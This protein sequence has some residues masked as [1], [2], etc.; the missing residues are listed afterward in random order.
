MFDPNNIS[1]YYNLD[2]ICKRAK[3]VLI[4]NNICLINKNH[5]SSHTIFIQLAQKKKENSKNLILKAKSKRLLGIFILNK[6]F[7]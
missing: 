1:T 6:N 7:K 4:I 2:E 3:N 5:K